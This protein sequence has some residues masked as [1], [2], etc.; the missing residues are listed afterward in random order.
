MVKGRKL[1]CW[2]LCVWRGSDLKWSCDRYC[3]RY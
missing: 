1:S 2:Q 3:F